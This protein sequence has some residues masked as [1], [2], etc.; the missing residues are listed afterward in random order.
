MCLAPYHRLCP[1][2]PRVAPGRDPPRRCLQCPVR[3]SATERR[4]PRSTASHQSAR[5]E[6]PASFPLPGRPTADVRS[7][8]F[9]GLPVSRSD[10]VHRLNLEGSS[11]WE[12]RTNEPISTQLLLLLL[13]YI[14][15]VVNIERPYY[16]HCFFKHLIL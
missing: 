2:G 13:I 1:A 6:F 14:I 9:P 16:Y 5:A 3:P 8:Q 12:I 10:A 15:V 4:S 11:R 7:D